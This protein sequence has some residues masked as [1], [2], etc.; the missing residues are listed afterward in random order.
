M[1]LRHVLPLLLAWLTFGCA[2]ARTRACQSVAVQAD[3]TKRAS[4]VVDDASSYRRRVFYSAKLETCVVAEERLTGVESGVYDLSSEV[5][6][7]IPDFP[8]LHCDRDG[9]RVVMLDSIR[10]LRGYVTNVPYERWLDDGAG[11]PPRGLVDPVP[12]P[13]TAERCHA[14][15]ENFLERL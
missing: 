9:A 10:A 7:D 3:S 11:G 15:F 14:L 12:V 6:R 5:V 13:Y 2:N 8:L 4:G 1:R